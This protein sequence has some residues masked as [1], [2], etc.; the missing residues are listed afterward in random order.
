[1]LLINKFLF[2]PSEKLYVE[3]FSVKV[4]NIETEITIRPIFYSSRSVTLQIFCTLAII[5]NISRNHHDCLTTSTWICLWS[6]ITCKSLEGESF[7]VFQLL[8][9]AL[10]VLCAFVSVCFLVIIINMVVM[11]SYFLWFTIRHE[12]RT[13]AASSIKTAYCIHRAQYQLNNRIF[14]FFRSIA[15]V[16]PLY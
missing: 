9:N 13:S 15:D 11:S 12:L 7:K 10:P 3:F 8:T 14:N 6:E 4:F 16:E 1:M 5:C 2:S